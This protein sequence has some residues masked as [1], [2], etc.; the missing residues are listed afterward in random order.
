MSEQDANALA[1]IGAQ[2]F[3]RLFGWIFKRRPDELRQL[4]K[5]IFSPTE[6]FVARC[7]GRV[8]GAVVIRTHSSDSEADK[9]LQ[10]FTQQLENMKI[11][12]TMFLQSLIFVLDYRPQKDEIY[13]GKIAVA[14]DQRGKGVGKALMQ[15]VYDMGADMGL[16]HVTL[17]VKIQNTDAKRLYNR[18]GFVDEI[19]EKF[20][21]YMR[22]LL[23]SV[24]G[25]TGVHFLRKPLV[26]FAGVPSG[27]RAA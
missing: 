11:W 12:R 14:E 13:I 21:W 6:T 2:A 23:Y 18:E 16:Q 3:Q 25:I 4:F 1:D 5:L 17:H 15:H 20:P 22:P 9:Q 7:D 8:V 26:P 10:E 24:F 27:K 19:T